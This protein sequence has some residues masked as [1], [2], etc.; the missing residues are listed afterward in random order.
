M[1]QNEIELI[2]PLKPQKDI[3]ASLCDN[4]YKN[5]LVVPGSLRDM[6]WVL[7]KH[8]QTPQKVKEKDEIMA[9]L[10]AE[11][12]LDIQLTDILKT[13]IQALATEPCRLL[14]PIKLNEQWYLAM[15]KIKHGKIDAAKLWDPKGAAGPNTKSIRITNHI[16]NAIDMLG[17]KPGHPKVKPS[18]HHRQF[19][20]LNCAEFSN[21]DFVIREALYHKFSR[22]SINC[23]CLFSGQ[24]RPSTKTRQ[25]ILSIY[26]DHL[27]LYIVKT[28]I[29]NAKL[30]QAVQST[31]VISA[32]PNL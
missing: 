30:Q 23:F 16:Q 6:E 19:T 15:I 24:Q 31:N 13:A 17:N 8:I 25:I 10:D 11:Q 29:K 2:V 27:R 1:P 21:M 32:Q 12:G 4:D 22:L 14:I 18:A 5:S 20:Y 28:M 3:Y 7:Q 9:P 26:P